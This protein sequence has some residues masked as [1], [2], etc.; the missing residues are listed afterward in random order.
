ASRRAVIGGVTAAAAVAT[1][2]FVLRPGG[3]LLQPN[4]EGDG[5]RKVSGTRSTPPTTPATP[6]PTPSPSP[7][8]FG[9]EVKGPVTLTG[10]SG[11]ATA[12]AAL[13]ATVACGTDKGAVLAWD[14]AAATPLK[15]LGDGGGAATSMAIGG[16][17]PRVASGHA[18]GRMR[19][20]SLTGGGVAEHRAGDP[21]IAVSIGDRP[22]AVSQK[23]DGLRDLYSVVRIW[24]IST[25]KQL[26][27]TIT[28]HFQGIRGLA[29]GRLGG[30]D[31]LV[32]GDGRERVRVRR[33]ATGEVVSFFHTGEIGG[34]ELLTCGEVKGKPVLVSTHQDATLRVYDLASGKRRKKWT[35]S[36]QSPDDRGAAALAAGR[37]G[38]VP[39]AVVAHSPA[40]GDVIVRVWSLDSGEII[41]SLGPGP[42]GAIRALALADLAGRPVVVGAG[43]DRTM[44]MWSLG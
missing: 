30:H 36:D 17:G 7:E 27:P 40:G 24:D 15:R 19:L 1:A 18:D 20:W 11:A 42:G 3:G 29:F 21:V 28:E 35:F 9:T 44:R 34:I 2:A 26:G 5:G 8:P 41:G 22:V 38:K 39:I 6:S 13:G 32:T 43:E 16:Q 25:G 10:G 31:V 14:A 12:V 37:L 23:Y 33:V 4:G